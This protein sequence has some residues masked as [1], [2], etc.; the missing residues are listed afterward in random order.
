MRV[1]RPALPWL[2]DTFA[3]ARPLTRHYLRQRGARSVTSEDAVSRVRACDTIAPPISLPG[4]IAFRKNHSTVLP[5]QRSVSWAGLLFLKM[6][7]ICGDTEPSLIGTGMKTGF[8]CVPDT[9]L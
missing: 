3:L 5:T 8:Y 6:T 4:Q 7:A 2:C 1:Q 9:F